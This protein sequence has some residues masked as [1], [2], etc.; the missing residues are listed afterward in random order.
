MD[1]ECALIRTEGLKQW[2]KGRNSWKKRWR[3]A[4]L[5]AVWHGR[6]TGGLRLQRD[7]EPLRGAEFDLILKLRTFTVEVRRDQDDAGL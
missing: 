3:G 4:H 5:F 7:D 6:R 2:M 1:R